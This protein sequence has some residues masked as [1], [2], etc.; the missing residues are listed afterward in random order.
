MKKMLTLFVCMLS[1]GMARP[2]NQLSIQK[3]CAQ[4]T[5]DQKKLLLEEFV[6]QNMKKQKDVALYPEIVAGVLLGGTALCTLCLF[7]ALCIKV[8]G[9]TC[10]RELE[11]CGFFKQDKEN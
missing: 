1:F 2:H 5:D 11:S 9:E 4:L 10:I 8:Y 6:I 7:S 3:K